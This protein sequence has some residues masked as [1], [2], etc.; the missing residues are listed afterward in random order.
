MELGARM[1]LLALLVP[2]LL[3]SLA[4]GASQWCYKTQSVEVPGSFTGDVYKCSSVSPVLISYLWTP[5]QVD[6][7]CP[8]GRVGVRMGFACAIAQTD[9][10]GGGSEIW[11]RKHHQ[12]VRT[13]LP[14]STPCTRATPRACCRPT[15]RTK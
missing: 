7:L 8:T 12:H 6:I 15:S 1:A 5:V 2:L 11:A 4:E 10:P 3:A 13:S 14:R 9:S